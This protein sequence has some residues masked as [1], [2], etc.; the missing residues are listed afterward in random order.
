M[1]NDAEFKV[2]YPNQSSTNSARCESRCIPVES[3][4]FVFAPT[5][6]GM[7]S[8]REPETGGGVLWLNLSTLGT[9]KRK[10]LLC[11]TSDW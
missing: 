5:I 10:M 11:V 9:L 4:G 3:S 1:L 8:K 7:H 6:W 2:A